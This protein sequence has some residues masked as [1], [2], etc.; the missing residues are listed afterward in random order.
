MQRQTKKESETGVLHD[1]CMELIV[2]SGAAEGVN[3]DWRCSAGRC[4][5]F[6]LP[7][8]FFVAKFHRF[9]IGGKSD[10]EGGGE[11][12]DGQRPRVGRESAIK[13]AIAHED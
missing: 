7:C 4:D 1:S 5:D 3:D 11:E 6:L 13:S 12:Q 10:G 9:R 2:R 8:S